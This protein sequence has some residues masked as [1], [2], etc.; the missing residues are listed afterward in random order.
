MDIKPI[1]TFYNGYRFRSRLEARVA[2]LFDAI[3][4]PYEY[5]PEGYELKDGRRYLPDFYLRTENMFVEVKGIRPG[6]EKELERVVQFVN[7]TKNV[8]LLI[9]EIPN[10][11]KA[12]LWWFPVVWHNTLADS[13]TISRIALMAYY[14]TSEARFIRDFAVTYDPR[15]VALFNCE[16][17]FEDRFN[18]EYVLRPKTD[19]WMYRD[20]SDFL[21]YEQ[22]IDEEH[23]KV[24]FDGYTAARQARFEHGEMPTF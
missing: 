22:C 14:A 18:A 1:E 16:Y 15:N 20:E 8:V 23:R 7:E 5:E 6:I 12:C 24:L 19:A 13:T 4:M 10:P 11:D 9:S 21:S 17:C 2:V 3:S